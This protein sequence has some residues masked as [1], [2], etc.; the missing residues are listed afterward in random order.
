MNQLDLLA[1]TIHESA[2]AGQ[3]RG[4]LEALPVVPSPRCQKATGTPSE[5]FRYISLYEVMMIK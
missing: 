2:I 3:S 5:A 1:N 4:N